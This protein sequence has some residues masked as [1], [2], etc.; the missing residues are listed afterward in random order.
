VAYGLVENDQVLEQWVVNP[1]FSDGV[2][3]SN[4]TR[5]A[6]GRYCFNNLAFDPK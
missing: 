4:L 3:T 2:S 5:I 1:A 6:E